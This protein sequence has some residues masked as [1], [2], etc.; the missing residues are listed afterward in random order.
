MIF[1]ITGQTGSGKSTVSEQFR[2]LGVDVLDADFAARVVCE[3]GTPCLAE[4]I[5][6]FGRD[7]LLPNGELNRRRLGTVVFSD[8]AKLERLS[9]ITH[10]YIREWVLQK[11]RQSKSMLCAIDGAVLIGSNMESL[12]RA[13]VAVV[14]EPD[15]RKKR[16]MARDGLSEEEAVKRIAAQEDEDF[17]R[18]HADFIIENNSGI[19]ALEQQTKKIYDQMKQWI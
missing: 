14:A 1:G 3:P 6:S 10:Y 16:I 5:E 8:P 18:K 17:Y 11:I 15:I 4:I 7:M 2:A 13:M 19:Q 12:C 9:K